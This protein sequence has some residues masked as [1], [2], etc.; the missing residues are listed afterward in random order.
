MDLKRR[1]V[2]RRKTHRA[3]EYSHRPWL[4]S[5]RSQSSLVHVCRCVRPANRESSFHAQHV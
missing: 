2:L 5:T 3:F 1:C 4:C